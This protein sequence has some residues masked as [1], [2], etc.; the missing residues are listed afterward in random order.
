MSLYGLAQ[1]L[2]A[3][4][5]AHAETIERLGADRPEAD[6]ASPELI[7]RIDRQ[8]ERVAQALA[9]DDPAPVAKHVESL[10]KGLRIA[11][12]KRTLPLC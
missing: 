12:R 10:T 11:A 9:G 6:G 7:E 2:A 5:F 1:V 4:L 8:R 3:H